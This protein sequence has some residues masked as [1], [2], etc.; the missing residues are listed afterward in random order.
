MFKGWLKS[1]SGLDETELEAKLQTSSPVSKDDVLQDL[2]LKVMEYQDSKLELMKQRQEGILLAERFVNQKNSQI[3]ELNDVID[4]TKMA[5]DSLEGK[6]DESELLEH[7]DQAISRDI[8]I[9]ARGYSSSDSSEILPTSGGME[10][11]VRPEHLPNSK[12]SMETP[13]QRR[14]DHPR[15]LVPDIPTHF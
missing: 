9:S 8:Q 2:K 4:A 6:V 15:E 14:I 12:S 7:L 13:A 10:V 1:I 11:S 5:I 3:D